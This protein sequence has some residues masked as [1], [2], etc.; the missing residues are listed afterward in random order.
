[1]ITLSTIDSTLNQFQKSYHPS[2]MSLISMN[3]YSSDHWTSDFQGQL[4]ES[5]HHGQFTPV[6]P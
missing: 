6:K 1:M 3:L 2:M 4:F 5:L